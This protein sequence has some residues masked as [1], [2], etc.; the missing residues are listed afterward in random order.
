MINF[1]QSIVL[2]FQLN[3]KMLLLIFLLNVLSNCLGN[4]KNIFDKNDKKQW[5]YFFIGIDAAIFSVAL[6]GFSTGRSICIVV[7]FVLGKIV[8]AMLS[9]IIEDKLAFGVLE[10][11]IIEKDDQAFTL[12]DSLRSIG[13]TVNTTKCFGMNGKERFM[14]IITIA[15]KELK[16][17][18]SIL[19]RFDIYNPNI[20]V[21]EIKSFGGKVNPYAE[22]DTDIDIDVDN[23]KQKLL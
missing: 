7:A 9:D 15:R 11:T 5:K 12:A 22:K 13:Y 17:L 6:K 3:Y 2:D 23:E 19:E 18:K 4:L 20:V 10:V 8:G 1:L 16:L 21:K 14:I